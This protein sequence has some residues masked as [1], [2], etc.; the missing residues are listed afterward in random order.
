MIY[1]TLT[2]ALIVLALGLPAA[3]A[4]IVTGLVIRALWPKPRP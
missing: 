4:G 3:F 1:L 2:L